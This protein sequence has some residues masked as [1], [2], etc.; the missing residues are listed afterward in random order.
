MRVTISGKPGAG[1]STVARLL[2]RRLKLRYFEVGKV[3]Q[4]IA[5][6]R[7]VSIGELMELAKSDGSVDEEID[8]YQKDLRNEDNFVVDGRLSHVFIPN[9]VHV[10]LD[11]DEGVAARRIFGKPR[12]PD[13]PKYASVE[14]VRKDIHRRM[15]NNRVQWLKYYKVDYLDVKQYDVVIDTTGKS[16]EDVVEELVDRIKNVKK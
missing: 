7:G 12:E 14:E 3:A 11:I 15:L 2:A 9:A 8:R 16:V 6:R 4:E 5:L 13:E 10:F 1:K